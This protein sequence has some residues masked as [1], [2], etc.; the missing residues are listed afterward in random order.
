L[1]EAAYRQGCR[2]DA[3]TEYFQGE[4][5]ASLIARYHPL[6]EDLL[7][8]REP[9]SALPWDCIDAGVA[10]AFLIGERKKSLKEEI[11]S[12][13]MDNCTNLCGNCDKDRQ[14]VENNIHHKVISRYDLEDSGSPQPHKPVPETHR[15]IF[16][17]SKTGK[18]VFLPHLGVIEIF[19]MAFIRSDI[20][21]LFTGGFNPLPKLD[22]ASPLAVG[23]AGEGEIASLDTTASFDA[24][25]FKAALNRTLPQGFSITSAINIRIPGGAK[26][27]SLTSLLWGYEYE[28]FSPQNPDMVKAPDEKAYRLAQKGFYGLRRRS[29]LARVPAGDQPASYF[30]VYR[31]LY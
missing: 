13:C 17:F 7:Q 9:G 20:P 8:A 4:R 27:H 5:W 19:S 14:I 11:T 26:K 24:E 3:W 15:I 12:P 16:S 29:V 31:S 18:A 28:G 23:I 30:T 10:G 1:I 25:R 21:V 2:L 22:F 6:R